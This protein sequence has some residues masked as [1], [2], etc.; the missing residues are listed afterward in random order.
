MQLIITNS[1]RAALA[2]AIAAGTTL[3]IT[4]VAIGSGKYTAAAAATA[5]QT[6]IKR[7]PAAG[8]HTT[9][10]V[11]HVTAIDDSTASYSV[12][13]IGLITSTGVLLAVYSQASWIVQKASASDL[14]LALD[15]AISSADAAAITFGDTDFL[16]P[17]ASSTKAGVVRLATST[18]IDAGT[19]AA[20]VDAA[21]LQSWKSRV[22][23][24]STTTNDTNKL[25][26]SAAVYALTQL[27]NAN[28]NAISTINSLL[29][30]DNVSMDT[31]QEIVDVIEAATGTLGSLAI[32]NIAGLQTALDG[33]AASSH[34]HSANDL[35]DASTSGKGVV[36]LENSYTSTSQIKAA[37]ANALKSLYDWITN[38]TLDTQGLLTG[39]CEFSGGTLGASKLPPGWSNPYRINEGQYEIDC[40]FLSL[41]TSQVILVNRS[42]ELGY[43]R[44]EQVSTSKYRFYVGVNSAST[45][46]AVL[47]D[48]NFHFMVQ[49]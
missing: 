1:G 14:V 45:Q 3:S 12:G 26:T 2:A 47:K 7:L 46:S 21:Q 29:T 30:S 37:T 39:Y 35:P 4:D 13:E 5:L 8:D 36:Q 22:K 6:E 34:S 11:I 40:G 16:L 27:I 44:G 20:A 18:E 25:A 41:S 10:G 15:I 48:G 24:D 9:A 32:A 31:L 38:R 23:T 19:A 17:A 42:D 43:A 28:T 33:K 49:R